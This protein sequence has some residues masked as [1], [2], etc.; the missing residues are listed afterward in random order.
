MKPAP[1]PAVTWALGI[2]CASVSLAILAAPDL[3]GVLGGTGPVRWPGQWLTPAFAHGFSRVS[4]LPHL[5][6]N[7]VLL[8][9]VG[10]FVERALGSRRFAALTAVALA[11]FVLARAASG[12]GVNGAS[13]FLWSFAPPAA[14]ALWRG[15]VPEDAASRIQVALVVMWGIVPLA[16]TV[17]PFADGWEGN[18]VEA[19]GL[20]NLYHGTATLAGTLAAVVWRGRLMRRFA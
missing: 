2:A 5:A 3:Y 6:G 20:A 11:F 12:P 15:E 1:R 10:P 18:P 7:L 16:M 8:A 13:V 17:V 4:L 19:F 9:L 14:L